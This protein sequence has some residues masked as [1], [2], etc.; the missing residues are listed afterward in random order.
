MIESKLNN[1]D[2]KN[3]RVLLRADLNVPIKKGSIL[4]EYRLRKLTPTINLIHKKGGRIVMITHIGRPTKP[5][6]SLSTKQLIPWFEQH[7]YNIIFAP[8]IKEAHIKSEESYP[9]VLLE[10][11]RFFPGEKNKNVHF[12]QE[13]A[14]LGDY[15]VNDAFGSMHRDDSSITIVPTYWKI[16][17]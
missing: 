17:R 3:K 2:I 1:L 11:L 13:L 10:N 15:Y 14:T 4:D 6:A 8:T 9:L 12:A 5:D 7:G 16:A